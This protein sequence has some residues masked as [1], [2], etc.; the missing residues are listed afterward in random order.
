MRILLWAPFGA[1][2]HYWGP[3]TSA[4]RLYR[5]NK[6][7]EVRVTL[8]HGSSRQGA[9]PTVYDEQI[10]IGNLE[11]KGL[12]NVVLFLIKSTFWILRHRKKYD[13]FHG[14]TAY[15]YT[16]IPALL[17][18]SGNKK[19]FIKITGVSGGFTNNGNLSKI[20]GFSAL[21]KHQS[22]RMSG[23]FSV[24]SDISKSL[25][26][27]G[28]DRAR[29]FYI[30]NGV[31]TDRFTP[32]D[33]GEKSALRKANGIQDV[34]TICYIGGLTS[35]KR[36]LPIVE[37]TH[38]LIEQGLSLQFLIVG[39]DRENGIIET[40]I[41]S[42]ISKHNLKDA[43]IRI[44]HTTDPE[45]YFKVSD[46]FVLNSKFEGLSN[47]LL[48]AMSSGLPCVASPASGTTDLIENEK[49]GYLTDGSSSD[50]SKKI[51]LLY[52]D[53]DLYKRISINA[54]DKILNGFSVDFVWGQ[55]IKLFEK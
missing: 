1:G 46:V 29:V 32:A 26:E 2:T 37:A 40:E 19:A 48:E 35:N 30:P 13:V 21:R 50:I 39:P 9:F 36:I 49:T 22:N 4:Y 6:D 24:S 8:V 55:H 53:Q 43:C 41:S 18:S 44:E 54:R 52:S 12:F 47:S 45:L 23:Y 15:F 20:L 10:Q 28:I 51:S 3:G 42:Y 34:F 25:V 17:F 11:K 5:S 33:S 16:F 38:D 7:Q 27:Q 31:D 14:L